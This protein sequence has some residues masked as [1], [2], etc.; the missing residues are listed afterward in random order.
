MKRI[1]KHLFLLNAM[2]APVKTVHRGLFRRQALRESIVLM[3]PVMP[4]RD[5]CAR[6]QDHHN[7]ISE[8]LLGFSITRSVALLLPLSTFLRHD[9]SLYHDDLSDNH[10]TDDDRIDNGFV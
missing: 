2:R 5:E 3:V 8:D 1:A 4:A 9:S 10:P 7:T 6:Q